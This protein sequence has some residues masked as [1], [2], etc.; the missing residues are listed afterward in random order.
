[1]ELDIYKYED[2][3]ERRGLYSRCHIEVHRLT[4]RIKTTT[5]LCLGPSV[6]FGMMPLSE[7]NGQEGGAR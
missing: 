7:S 5:C 1:M 6:P 2:G 4:P 3:R